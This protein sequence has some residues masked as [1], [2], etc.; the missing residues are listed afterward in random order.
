MLSLR[1]ETAN[2]FVGILFIASIG[3]LVTLLTLTFLEGSTVTVVGEMSTNVDTYPAT[4]VW[5]PSYV[6]EGPCTVFPVQDINAW[7][8]QPFRNGAEVAVGV[9]IVLGILYLGLKRLYRQVSEE[10]FP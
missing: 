1:L 7:H 5:G 10:T 6:V 3:I 4:W 9:T 8:N 2:R